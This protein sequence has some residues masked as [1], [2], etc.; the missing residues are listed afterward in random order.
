MLFFGKY[1]L[2]CRL[3]K[4]NYIDFEWET[5]TTHISKRLDI[6][7]FCFSFY[8]S[9]TEYKTVKC[10]SYKCKSDN[11]KPHCHSTLSQE[12]L[13]I[14]FCNDCY[15]MFNVRLTDLEERRI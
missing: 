4:V 12:P 11:T 2:K 3:Y 8:I 9:V 5:S 13:T 6:L 14:H 1:L 10:S 15:N 7:F